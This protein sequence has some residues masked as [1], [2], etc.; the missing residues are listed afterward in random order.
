M[1]N[2]PEASTP[3]SEPTVTDGPATDGPATGDTKTSAVADGETVESAIA[4]DRFYIRGKKHL[5]CIGTKTVA[6]K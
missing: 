4:H 3:D 6:G 2:S 1:T 5:F